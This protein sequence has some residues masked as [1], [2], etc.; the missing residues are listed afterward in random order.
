M[1]R[2]HKLTQGKINAA[3]MPGLYS[4]GGNLHLRVA[5][6]GSRQWV[7]RYTLNHRTRDYGIGP[8]PTLGLA[9][10]RERAHGLRRLLV[11]KID[12]IEHRNQQRAG[13]SVAA[14]K[15]MTFDTAAETYIAEHEASWRSRRHRNEWV[16]TLRAYASPVFGKLPVSAVDTGLVMRVLKP[17]WLEKPIVATRLRGRIESILDWAKVMGYRLGENPARFVGHLDHLLPDQT[18][19]VRHHE[20]LPYSDVPAFMQELRKLPNAAV[21]ALEFVILT[22]SRGGE[23][24]GMQWDEVDLA[25]RE[26]VIPAARMKAHREHRVPL[27]DAALAVLKQQADIRHSDLVFP[28]RIGRMGANSLGDILRALSVAATPHGFRSSFRDWCSE[29]TSAPREIAEMALAHIVGSEVERAYAR[30]TLFEKRA[31]LMEAWGRYCNG[32]G[33]VVPLRASA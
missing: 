23:V 1:G 33:A 30:S 20:A 11:D 18:R 4:D 14:A 8:Y 3:R 7:F 10:A 31:E 32:I 13:A 2:L 15:H 24:A 17:I 6:G 22:A 19:A 28:G 21:R 27:S 25:K 26:W 5:E 9:D 12:P 29:K 16:N